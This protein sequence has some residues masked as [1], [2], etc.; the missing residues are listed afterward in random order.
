MG[1]KLF[2]V[3]GAENLK[4]FASNLFLGL[5]MLSRFSGSSQVSAGRV[6]AK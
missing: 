4:V 3:R 6:L 1:D 5:G 2:H